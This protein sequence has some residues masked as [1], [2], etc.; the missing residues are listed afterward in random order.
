MTFPSKVN[1]DMKYF[2]ILFGFL[3]LLGFTG[4]AFAQYMGD[5]DPPEVLEERIGVGLTKDI[6]WAPPIKQIKQFEREPE[7]V[8]CNSDLELIFKLNGSPACVMAETKTKLIERGWG[9]ENFENTTL[10]LQQ[11]IDSCA[12]DS[13]KE[14]MENILRYTNETHVFLNLGCE[15]KTIGKFVS[16]PEP[17]PESESYKQLR[18]AKKSLQNA[19]HTNVNL[20]PFYI[21]DVIVGYGIGD[22]FLIVD[23]L[24]KYF[25]SDEDRKLIEQKIID[26]TGEKVDIEFNSSSAIAPANIESVFPYVWNSLLNKKGIEFTPKEQSYANNDEG[27]DLYHRVCSPIIASNGTE[28]YVSSTFIYEPFEITG[29]FIDKFKPDDC[30]KVW[31]TDSILVEPDRILKL[32]LENY[33]Q[34]LE[35]EN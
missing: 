15:W 12:N 16:E 2:V 17:Q 11:V 19:Y 26:I 23:M 28:F 7:N 22:G 30:Y 9:S 33:H 32:W 4:I 25:V 29:T 20:G 6:T 21:K 31:R 1:Q 8:K 10:A 13:P 24:E 18:D 34:E 3:F 5:N 35:N 27:Y 14:R